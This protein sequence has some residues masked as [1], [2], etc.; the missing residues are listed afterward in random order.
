MHERH[1]LTI[2]GHT[3]A[4]ES[5]GQGLP[6]EETFVFLHGITANMATWYGFVEPF[7]ARGRVILLTLPGHYPATLPPGYAQEQITAAA[8]G[9]LGGAALAA[10]LPDGQAATLIGHSTGGFWALATAWRAPEQV[11]RVVSLA[12]F[13]YGR[14]HGALGFSQMMLRRIGMAYWPLFALSYRVPILTDA[15]S[16]G[17]W[18]IYHPGLRA[19][20]DRAA[21]ARVVQDGLENYRRMDWRAV[22]LIFRAMRMQVD[23]RDH[24][25]EIA[26]PVL[27]LT[28][29]G[30]PIVPPYHAEIIAAGVP[31]AT[32][33]VMPGGG[34][35]V[36][37][38]EAQ[39]DVQRAVFEWLDNGSG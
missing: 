2:D 15:L 7:A 4:Y 19:S 32:L 13:A 27:A 16:V 28:A 31:N 33:R 21:I 30:D 18:R 3:L 39:A 6:G 34:G 5:W 8:W 22:A 24:L 29:D 38:I 35:H 37:H 36:H 20:R 12:G 23:M 26:A 17:S 9:D 11:R 14:W 25:G 10:L 1:T